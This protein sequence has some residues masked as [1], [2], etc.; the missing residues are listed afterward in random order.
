MRTVLVASLLML[1][2][3]SAMAANWT[4]DHAHSKLGFVAQW[5]GQPFAARFQRWEAKIDFDPADL[6]H[7]KAEVSIDMT[8][9]ISG[10]ADLDK[11]LP[12]AQGFD[13]ARF[14]QARFVSTS[15]RR[16]G[17]NHYEAVGEL[18]I[19]GIAKPLTL[20]FTL[21][22]QGNRAHV[23]GETTVMRNQFGVGS[24]PEWAGE[25]PVAHGVKVTV[26]LTASKPR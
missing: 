18:T 6:T 1:S 7:A 25:K 22:M 20:P 8:S 24:G 13:A 14:P 23:T 19:R 17:D 9:A 26:D 11:N 2:A 5:S 16:L 3:T 4:V 15:F 10:E 21:T 12:G